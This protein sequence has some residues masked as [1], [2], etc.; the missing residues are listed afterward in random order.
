MYCL[1]DLKI[2]SYIRSQSGMLNILTVAGIDIWSPEKHSLM[3]VAS[4]IKKI[5]MVQSFD[6][7]ASH[8]PNKEALKL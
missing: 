2:H 5:F 6:S 3:T 4:S 8:A 7:Y 1:P